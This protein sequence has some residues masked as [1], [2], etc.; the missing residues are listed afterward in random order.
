MPETLM[1]GNTFPPFISAAVSAWRVETDMCVEDRV[2]LDRGW[3]HCVPYLKTSS[4]AS[5]VG[6]QFLGTAEAS[7][8]PLPLLTS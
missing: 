1:Q 5:E 3:S 2:S 6:A 7:P 8:C 4:L